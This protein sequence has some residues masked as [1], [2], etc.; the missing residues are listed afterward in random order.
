M[1]TDTARVKLELASGRSEITAPFHH[2]ARRRPTEEPE[3]TTEPV[4][5]SDSPTVVDVPL[6][7]TLSQSEEPSDERKAPLRT[8]TARP[9]WIA[10]IAAVIAV[11]VGVWWVM[12]QQLPQID[13]AEVVRRN[14]SAAQQAMAEGRYTDP[15][16]RSAFHYYNAV[17]A[18]DP[19]N[20]HALA[21]IDDIADRHLTHA[22]LL[23]AEKRIAEAGVAL[24]KARRVRPDHEGLAALDTQLRA[25]LR[26]ILAS[27]TA[28]HARPSDELEKQTLLKALTSAARRRTATVAALPAV[29]EAATAKAQETRA[30]F[31]ETPNS[32]QA[33]GTVAEPPSNPPAIVSNPPASASLADS[34]RPAMETTVPADIERI[35]SNEAGRTATIDAPAVTHAAPS[36]QQPAA[37]V[38]PGEPKLI[39]M[40]QPEY[41]QEA[42][43]RG[44]EGWVDLSLRISAAGDVIEPRVEGTNRGRLFNRA[45]LTAVEQWKYQPRPDHSPETTIH[46][47]LQFR[48]R[49]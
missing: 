37:A 33:T 27:T 43:M 45:A 41:P 2:S 9:S 47:R 40:V 15:P 24:E 49:K 1:A 18:L 4:S 28:V 7:D 32:D 39:R 25:E 34:H 23:L 35:A 31:H 30:D 36:E 42:L 26:K 8:G 13:P 22:R 16:E 12:L 46:V 5:S 29:P 17:L 38:G 44:I 21:G 19:T 10:M 3:H 6:A 14:L 48:H 11:G 20:I